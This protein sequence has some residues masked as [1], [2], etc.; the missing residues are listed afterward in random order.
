MARPPSE[1]PIP[2]YDLELRERLLACYSLPAATMLHHVPAPLTPT[3]ING[4][5]LC[6]VTMASGRVLKRCGAAL[7]LASEFHLLEV[8]TP[9]VWRRACSPS[10]RGLFSLHAATDHAGLNRLL[11][12]CGEK[13]DALPS[14]D[15]PEKARKT[16]LS[17]GFRW[18]MGAAPLQL[19]SDDPTWPRESVVEGPERA[20]TL[21]AHPSYRFFTEADRCGI[22]A[23]PVRDYARST[24]QVEV[25]VPPVE[26]LADLLRIASGDVELD[27]ALLQKRVTQTVF[28]PS[29]RIQ[30]LPRSAPSLGAGYGVRCRTHQFPAATAY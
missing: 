26:W 17:D 7:D 10:E 24:R 18:W 6:S 1:W 4:R 5:A 20:E 25:N 12:Q 11:S 23:V 16:Q 28:F 30:A 14:A 9:V 2:I 21:L 22:R 19:A 13:A 8:Q 15:A 29:E 27:H 3:L